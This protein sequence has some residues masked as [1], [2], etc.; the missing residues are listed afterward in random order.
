[1]SL[2]CN[3][4]S[5]RKSHQKVVIW[6][7][8][9]RFNHLSSR[10]YRTSKLCMIS[11]RQPVSDFIIK[12]NPT[13]HRE[14]YEASTPQFLYWIAT[15]RARAS[16]NISIKKLYIRKRLILESNDSQNFMP[17]CCLL[18]I[19]LY[20]IIKK[21]R[22]RTKVWTLHTIFFAMFTCYWCLANKIYLKFRNISM[23]RMIVLKHTIFWTPRN[24][25]DAEL[26]VAGLR[27]FLKV[28]KV[29]LH[30]K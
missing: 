6:I 22:K 21:K 9:L 16:D 24:A 4:F 13:D 8:L 17:A 20:G 2:N 15:S 12:R 11:Q 23:F 25:T 14:N 10:N 19:K 3:N 1:M 26:R 27:I 29:H 28:F 30:K 7:Y 5:N 18:L